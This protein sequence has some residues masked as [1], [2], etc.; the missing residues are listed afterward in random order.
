MIEKIDEDLDGAV[1]EWGED[2]EK[3]VFVYN[4]RRGL[5][6]DIPK[7]L[8]EKQRQYPEIA[9]DHLSSDGLWEVA[10]ELPLQKRV[11]VLGAP[12]GYEGN[13]LVPNIDAPMTADVVADPSEGAWLVIIQDV[14]K[15]VDIRSILR[16]LQPDEPFGA[17]T[18]VRPDGSAS[19]QEA[20]AY[21]RDLIT[22]L[23]LKCRDSLR[24]RFAVF[25]IAPI[26]LIVHLGFLL[27]DSVLVRPYKLHIDTVSWEWPDRDG[28]AIDD[29]IQVSGVPEDVVSETCEVVIRVSLSERVGEYETDAVL[30]DVSVQVDVFVDNP[31]LNWIRSPHQLE[32]L[33]EVFRRVLSKIRR[34]APFC[35]R[36]H[37]FAAVPAPAA[38]V[39]GQQVN[40]RMN[41]PVCVYQYARQKAP[42]YELALT[43]GQEGI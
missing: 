15:P 23:L 16:A 6:P 26:P 13:F 5:P 32:R 11:E 7:I 9:I 37:L 1:V 21:Q 36:I 20:A 22:D 19:W 43:L 29:N 14:L 39:L 4:A 38:M 24:P 31:S 42:R 27:S 17:P 8:K 35:Q 12:V 41:P 2:M 30:P 33:A 28:E 40:P 34:K 18:F 25:S 3:W 10:R